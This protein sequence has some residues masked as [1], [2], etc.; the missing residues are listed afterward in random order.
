VRRELFITG[1]ARGGTSLVGRMIDAHP[2]AAIAIDAFLPLFRAL[3]NS[4]LLERMPDFDP[5]RPMEDGYF[6]ADQ[7]ARLATLWQGRLDCPLAGTDLA[8]LR[9]AL[10]RRAAD[11]SGD[12]VGT[13]GNIAGMTPG[14][15]FDDALLRIAASRAAPADGVIGMKDLWAIDLLPALARGRPSARFIAILRDPRDVVSSVLGFMAIDPG[16]VGHVLS[17]ARHWRKLVATLHA[18]A[19]DPLFAD[20]LLCVRYEDVVGD[21]ASFTRRAAAFVGL[22]D[23]GSMLRADRFR[24]HNTGGKWLGNSTFDTALSGITARPRERWREK[25]PPE[26]VA[27]VELTCGPEMADAGYPVT[28]PETAHVAR[29][30]VLSFLLADGQR[31]CSWRSDSGDAVR[32]YGCELTRRAVLALPDA[33]ATALEDAFLFAGYARH[34]RQARACAA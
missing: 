29:A 14:E 8:A 19:A 13:V 18:L 6:S 27:L 15:L 24:D 32:D 33:D 11:E 34:L 1:I 3:R 31:A 20:R 16:Q 23:D 30:D 12:L 2:A 17:I 9:D 28:L 21:P 22:P 10:R 25:L 5:A 26:A 4:I 7:R